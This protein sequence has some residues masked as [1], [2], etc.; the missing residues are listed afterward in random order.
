MSQHVAL[1]CR[2][3]PRPDGSYEGVDLQEKWGRE[4]AASTWPGVPVA[5]ALV[6]EDLDSPH[7]S[8][9][10][11]GH[12]FAEPLVLGGE[13]EPLGLVRDEVAGIKAVLA[14]GEVRKLRKRTNDRLAEIAAEGRPAGGRTFGYEHALDD[15]GRKTLRIVADQAEI[16]RDAADKILAGWSLSNVAAELTSR[17]VRGANGAVINYGTLRRMVTNPTVAGYRVYQ[18]EIVGRGVWKPILD[19]QTWQLVRAKLTK[20]RTVQTRNGGAYDISGDQF[21][22]HSTRSRRRF[23]LTGGIAICGEC[24]DRPTMH[25]QRRKVNGRRLAAIYTCTARYDIGIMADPLEQYVAERLLDEIERP[26]FLQAVADNDQSDRRKAIL[27]A[28]AAAERQRDELAQLWATPGELTASEWRSARNALA[29]Q[30]SALRREL[31]ELPA[32]MVSVD[33]SE[34]RESWPDMTLDERREMVE[35]FIRHVVVHRAKPGA[36]AFDPARVE[37]EWAL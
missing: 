15:E 7:V 30:E 25:A 3:S 24:G 35:L 6:A 23:L 22:A 28:L 4:Y 29:E 8:D 18:G 19:E 16:L 27:D 26:E 1:Y 21:G 33:M 5:D 10:A 31:A 34:V 32:P 11:G 12:P 36:K 2:L 9:P 20:P 13:L 14:A 17:G 37:I